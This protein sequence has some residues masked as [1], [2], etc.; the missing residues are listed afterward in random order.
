MS[1]TDSVN[2]PA[3][4]ADIA[5]SESSDAA[6]QIRIFPPSSGRKMEAPRRER[7]AMQVF[8][9]RP[10]ADELKMDVA[11]FELHTRPTEFDDFFAPEQVKQRYYPEVVSLLK[12][13]LGALEVFVFDH[14][15]RSFPR[16][17][18]KE[19]GVR[20]PVEG[21]HNDYTLTSGPKR[22]EEI[23]E[24]N[25]ARHLL[26]NRAALINVW[27]PLVGP[28]QDHPLAVC[29][30]RSTKLEDFIATQIQHFQEGD[31]ETPAHV[32]EVFSFQHNPQHRWYY[33]SD[34]Q[35]DEVIFLKCFDTAL[36][37]RARYTGHTGFRNPECPE[38]F[39]ARESIEAR[40]VVVFDE[41][42]T[43]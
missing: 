33:A 4:S 17:A 34:M 12:R 20:E 21:A 30:A 43:D 1:D 42:R 16:A 24:E 32:G 27:R 10:I 37:G 22:I 19:V 31:L 23:L 14:N 41:A 40:T 7:H 6:S 35:P 28:I 2:L 3:V 29:D 25:D 39:V 26:G 38:D 18:R 15:V 13:D 5:Y 11:G 8:D 36:D 9:C